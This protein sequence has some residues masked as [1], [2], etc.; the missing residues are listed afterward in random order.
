MNG[1]QEFKDILARIK[2][3]FNLREISL[4]LFLVTLI[5]LEVTGLGY[6]WEHTGWAI[7]SLAIWL[8]TCYVFRFLVAKQTTASGLINL[9]L[10]YDAFV[11]LT[12]LAIIVYSAGGVEGI[13]GMFFLFPI[14]YTSI[15]FPR[16]DALLIYTTA[17]VYYVLLVLLP[18]FNIIP[19][20]PYFDS[21]SDL[22]HN[23]NYV[24]NN[25]IFTV[26]TFYLVG[27]AANLIA[28]LLKKRATELELLK[29]ELE[30]EKITL[31]TK[32]K[33]RT[34]ELA[35]LAEGLDEKV[36]ER[37]KQLED[38]KKALE[39]FNKL[40]VGRELKMMELKKQIEELKKYQGDKKA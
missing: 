18:F 23:W 22:Y 3:T 15:V 40:S 38:E 31:E 6:Y 19:F 10:A 27:L 29:R 8:A 16:K 36:K 39:K 7:L 5:L 30:N 14:V 2:R 1:E 4:G 21:G 26:S 28:D 35:D 32:V 33:A 11:E 9:Y 20:W 25:I 24:M 37:T 17:S 13:G 12:L 34:K